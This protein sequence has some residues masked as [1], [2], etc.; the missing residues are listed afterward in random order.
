MKKL[1]WVLITAVAAV[2]VAQTSSVVPASA[3]AQSNTATTAKPASTN[4]PDH[5]FSV[6]SD[7][8]TFDGKTRQV[9]GYGNV[10]VTNAQLIL[11][12][13]RITVNFPAESEGDHPTNAIAETNVYIVS[14]DNTKGETNHL[15][16]DKATYSYNVANGITNELYTFTGHCTN[17]V[18]GKIITGEPMIWDTARQNLDIKNFKMV[19]TNASMFNIQR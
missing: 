2:A 8:G 3:P 6:S 19:G 12:C 17:I 4:S 10:V 15:T 14:V 18:N 1:L 11:T 9:V 7:H 16:C 13:E 5:T